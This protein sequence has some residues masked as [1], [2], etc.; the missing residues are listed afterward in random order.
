MHVTLTSRVVSHSSP[1]LTD[2]P[3]TFFCLTPSYFIIQFHGCIFEVM[4]FIH[5]VNQFHFS[6][7]SGLY[8]SDVIVS[9]LFD[10]GFFHKR[11]SLQGVSPLTIFLPEAFFMRPH[12]TICWAN[13]SN[14][15]MRYL[16]HEMSFRRSRDRQ[17]NKIG[18]K[19]RL[20][21]LFLSSSAHDPTLE[22]PQIFSIK[23][24]TAF[25]PVAMTTAFSFS[26]LPHVFVFRE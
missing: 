23:H 26:T 24:N 6:F 9:D 4:I 8:D 7:P 17:T 18:G 3:G 25:L 1:H 16:S 10:S 2:R 15:T 14:L 20:F 13:L 11:F 5:V 12:R 22:Q 21:V 19:C